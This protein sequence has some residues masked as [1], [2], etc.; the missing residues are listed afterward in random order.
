MA[1]IDLEADNGE[2][3]AEEGA[4]DN[5]DEAAEQEREDHEA[6]LEEKPKGT[7]VPQ[8]QVGD[9][10]VEVYDN[11]DGT[12]DCFYKVEAVKITIKSSR[13]ARRSPS[14]RTHWSLKRTRTRKHGCRELLLRR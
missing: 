2:K 6:K 8:K 4:V 3:L 12:Y 5:K 1:F 13:T 14:H 9:I 11:G 7:P 10:P